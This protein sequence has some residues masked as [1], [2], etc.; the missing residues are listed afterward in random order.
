MPLKKLPGAAVGHAYRG[1]GPTNF[2][3]GCVRRR[4]VCGEV[5]HRAST[6]LPRASLATRPAG[7]H[8]PIHLITGVMAFMGH[9]TKAN[10]W[11]RDAPSRSFFAG[12]VYRCRSIISIDQ[13]ARNCFSP[14][15][16][17]QRP[18]PRLGATRHGGNPV[19]YKTNTRLKELHPICRTY[20]AAYGRSPAAEHAEPSRTH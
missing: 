10:D 12:S 19:R 11:N 17:R 6:P 18:S 1:F 14:A 3:P 15:R 2:Q 20:R 13:K 4:H 8:S 16:M 9:S 7:C 5:M